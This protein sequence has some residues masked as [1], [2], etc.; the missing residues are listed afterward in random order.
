MSFQFLINMV[1]LIIVYVLWVDYYQ[2]FMVYHHIVVYLL[3]KKDLMVL[4][5]FITRMGLTMND[6]GEKDKVCYDDNKLGVFIYFMLIIIY[7]SIIFTLL[8]I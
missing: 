7:N 5:V 6:A 3:L 2:H 8:Y 1:D 4:N